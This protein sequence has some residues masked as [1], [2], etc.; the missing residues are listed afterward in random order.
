MV[1]EECPT[2]LKCLFMFLLWVYFIKALGKFV[3]KVSWKLK[4]IVN[5][6]SGSNVFAVLKP[7]TLQW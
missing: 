7:T 4:R 1:D 5:I 6:L 2:V 3:L